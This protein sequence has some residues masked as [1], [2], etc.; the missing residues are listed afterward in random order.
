MYLYL[1]VL[2]D[3]TELQPIYR[4]LGVLAKQIFLGFARNEQPCEQWKAVFDGIH[5][6]FE[7][8]YVP[9]NAVGDVEGWMRY[10]ISSVTDIDQTCACTF[11][12]SYGWSSSAS[13]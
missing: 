2:I 4:E 11:T 1:A 6:L 13:C 8:P 3:N 9:S 12:G 7:Q 10:A 5:G